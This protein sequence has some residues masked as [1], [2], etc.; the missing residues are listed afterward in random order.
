MTVLGEMQV[1]DG[2]EKGLVQMICKKMRKGRTL[3]T[4]ADE[5]EEEIYVIAPIYEVA[6][7]FFPDYD[8]ELVYE[9]VEAQGMFMR[10]QIFRYSFSLQI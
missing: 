9:E 4:I 1:N 8:S 2:M 10:K 6:S 3:E 5:L 7:K